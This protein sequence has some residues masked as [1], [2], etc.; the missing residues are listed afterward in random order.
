MLL[1]CSDNA[2]S[3]ADNWDWAAI[4]TVALGVFVG[5]SPY[6]NTLHTESRVDILHEQLCGNVVVDG[7][8][9]LLPVT[10][11]TPLLAPPPPSSGPREH[12]LVKYVDFMEA[13]LPGPYTMVPPLPVSRQ[14]FCTCVDVYSALWSTYVLNGVPQCV[15]TPQWIHAKALESM[16]RYYSTEYILTDRAPSRRDALR[17]VYDYMKQVPS[18]D[19]PRSD[20]ANLAVPCAKKVKFDL[21]KAKEV[22]L[23]RGYSSAEVLAALRAA[24]FE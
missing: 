21:K 9:L 20:L 5:E 19:V 8:A 6:H 13:A 15:F 11:L 14:L 18:L 23:D 17:S 7:N 16:L 10:C 24:V 3:L 2:E 12:R 22:V 1:C 4:D